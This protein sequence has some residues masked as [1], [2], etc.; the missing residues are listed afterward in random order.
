MIYTS[1]STGQ[2]KGVQIEH[3][4]VVNCLWSIGREISLSQ[5]DAW[6]AV[7]TVSFDIAGLELYL[8][9]ITGAKVIL[10]SKG[11]SSD[12]AQLLARMKASQATIMQATPSLWKLLQESGWKGN[13][14]FK[15]LCGGEALSRQ[16]ADQLLDHS[17]SVWNLY[18]PTES[19]IWS[20]VAKL[21]RMTNPS[22][23]VAPSRIRKSTFSMPR[24]QP[25][26][27]GVPG[28]LYIGGDGL[29]RGYLGH[30][31]L[32]AEKF[33]VNPFSDDPNSRLYRTGDRAKYQPT[34]HRIPRS[35]R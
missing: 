7:T 35:R 18:G 12:T 30:P 21:E 23:S 11:E 13:S 31:E 10:A 34:E 6:L 16:L 14:D 2:P 9:L 29:A 3:R 20:T 32:T 19:T 26:P 27:I 33:V 22:Q 24:L 4:S 8:P 1:G 25:V 28:D 15:I 5:R 17:S